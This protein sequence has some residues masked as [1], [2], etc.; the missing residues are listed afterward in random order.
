MKLIVVVDLQNEFLGW[1]PEHVRETLPKNIVSYLQKEMENPTTKLICTRDTH[2]EIDYYREYSESIKF[3][4]HCVKGTHEWEIAQEL[5][6]F[7]NARAY[8]G[9]WIINKDTFG[10]YEEFKRLKD[11]FKWEFDEIEVCG[12]TTDICVISNMVTLHTLFP[13][14]VMTCLMNL[15]N[16]TTED[17]EDMAFSIMK[18]MGFIVRGTNEKG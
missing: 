17:N 12:L 4:L 7:I 15:T 5:D 6:E 9:C 8:K 13:E 18:S 2:L 16:G 1:Q 11:L 14:A 3:D 10:E